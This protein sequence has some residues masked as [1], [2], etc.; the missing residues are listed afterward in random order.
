[1]LGDDLGDLLGHRIPSDHSRPLLAD[2]YAE[3]LR[4]HRVLDL[5]CGAGDSIDLFRS[6]DSGVAWVGADIEDSAEVAA[7]TRDDAEFVTFDGERLPFED[8]SFELV[9]CK[10]VLE[11]VARPPPPPA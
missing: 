5:G 8:G 4:A 11:H 10:Q 6:V 9:Y 2:H 1:M 7:R 3:R